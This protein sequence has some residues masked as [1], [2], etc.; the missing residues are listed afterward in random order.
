[1]LP[2]VIHVAGTN[3]KGSVVAFLRAFLEAAGYRTHV[4]TSPHL[5][6][7]NERIRLAGAIVDDQSLTDLLEECEEAQSDEPI[8]FFEITT[9][10]AFLAFVRTPADVVLLETG[11]GGRLDATSVVDR[12]ALNVL[13]PVSIDHQQFLG[14][15]IEEIAF[16][17]AGI[18]RPG[19]PCVSAAQIAPAARVIAEQAAAVGSPLVREG[20]DWFVRGEGATLSFED[21]SGARKLP[22]PALAGSHQIRNGGLAVACIDYLHDFTV[23]DAAIARGFETVEW[24]ARLQRLTRGPLARRLPGGWELWLDGGHNAAAGEMLAEQARKW[25][26]RPLHLIFGMLNSKDPKAFLAPLAQS[27]ASL[28]TVTIPGESASLTAAETA[29]AGTTL[30]ADAAPAAGVDEALA[31]LTANAAGPARVLICGSLYLAGSVLAENG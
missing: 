1:V 11:L 17:K 15:T 16:E 27:A 7:F 30:F 13:T 9:A 8:T 18:L 20:V 5:V 21:K 14:D 10:A 19:V 26:D 2:P 23:P 24:P 4:Y 22:L 31:A 29:A 25:R 6:K 28:R 3:G 12:P